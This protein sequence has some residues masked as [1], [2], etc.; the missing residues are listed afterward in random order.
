MLHVHVRVGVDENLTAKCFVCKI[1]RLCCDSA[2]NIPT[3]MPTGES[4]TEKTKAGRGGEEFE[5]DTSQSTSEEESSA[6]PKEGAEQGEEPEATEEE[7]EQAVDSE[8][9]EQEAEQPSEEEEEVP[10]EGDSQTT[11]GEEGKSIKS[12]T[13][14]RKGPIQIKLIFD[15]ITTCT[16]IQCTF[17]TVCTPTS[18]FCAPTKGSQLLIII[19]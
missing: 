9:A 6:S 18:R 16:C 13:I 12:Y 17:M 19:W 5:E 3:C 2:C 10:S 1:F 15:S 11:A 4:E 7:A 14:G 8:G